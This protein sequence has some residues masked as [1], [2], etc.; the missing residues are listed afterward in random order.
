MPTH[1]HWCAD[2]CARCAALGGRLMT[3]EAITSTWVNVALL[4]AA[5]G[6]D[7][8]STTARVSAVDVVQKRIAPVAG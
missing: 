8:L 6:P 2:P 5:L 1:S 3:A 7:G 4:L